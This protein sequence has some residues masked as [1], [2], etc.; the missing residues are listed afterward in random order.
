MIDGLIVHPLQTAK[1]K[2][3]CS[4]GPSYMFISIYIYILCPHTH[5][6]SLVWSTSRIPP[7][8]WKER[9]RK[10][11][12]QQNINKY[13]VWSN[14]HRFPKHVGLVPPVRVHHEN[15]TCTPFRRIQNI[16]SWTS[17][18]EAMF[19]SPFRGVCLQPWPNTR[20]W[21]MAHSEVSTAN[22]K[23]SAVNGSAWKSF[24]LAIRNG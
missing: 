14:N 20:I 22:A 7:P 4:P 23:V 5:N 15:S 3:V 24:S 19:T 10:A 18:W 21:V 11:R 2:D 6:G 8:C 17:R 12:S 1:R 13:R 16:L 9:Q